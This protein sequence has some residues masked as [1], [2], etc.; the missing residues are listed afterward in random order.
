MNDKNTSDVIWN[1]V[2]EATHEVL[3]QQSDSCPRLIDLISLAVLQ[4]IGKPTNNERLKEIGYHKAF[5]SGCSSTYELMLKTVSVVNGKPLLRW[6]ILKK[7]LQEAS[8]TE[9]LKGLGSYLEEQI[10]QSLRPQYARATMSEDSKESL[11]VP[12][13]DENGQ[14][15]P[16]AKSLI[17]DEPPRLSDD[18]D[19][20]LMTLKSDEPLEEYN[21]VVSIKIDEIPDMEMEL[22]RTPFQQGTAQIDV[23]VGDM[24]F[25]FLPTIPLQQ[26]SIQLQS[27]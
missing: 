14:P 6:Q 11:L 12:V 8:L 25:Q 13:L 24:N 17:L 5:C 16:L 22:G 21:A 15:T 7:I 1:A 23:D 27:K 26:L 20:F 19:R 18:E 9:W 3:T 4:L 10:G 2:N